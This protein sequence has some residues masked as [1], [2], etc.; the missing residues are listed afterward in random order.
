MYKSMA[1]TPFIPPSNVI[2]KP[3][4]FNQLGL[5]SNSN[6]KTFS[7]EKLPKPIEQAELLTLPPITEKMSQEQPS[8][9]KKNL[10]L[11]IS[12]GG[13]LVLLGGWFFWKKHQ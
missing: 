9:M 10:A 13:F 5:K 4:K 2:N 11:P 12:I 3:I 6:Q 8:Q 1:D 7:K